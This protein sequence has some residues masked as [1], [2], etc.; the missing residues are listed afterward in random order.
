MIHKL[1]RCIAAA[2]IFLCAPLARA[3]APED[4]LAV[5]RLL[6]YVAVDYREAVAGGAVIN[7]GEYAEMREFAATIHARL[8]DLPAREGKDRLLAQAAGLA[9]AIEAKQ[10]PAR[11]AEQAAAMAQA[12]LAAYPAP[13]SPTAP[14]DVRAAGAL[15]AEHCATCHGASGR[16]DGPV[17]AGM[18][19]PPINFHDRARHAS[20]SVFALYG[21]IANGVEGTAMPAFPQLTDAQ[22]WALAFHVGQMPYAAADRERG[23]SVWRGHP[24]ARDAVPSLAALVATTPA[25]LAAALGADDASA[26]TAFLRATPSAVVPAAS[27]SLTHAIA[28]IHRSVEAFSAGDAGRAADLALA[29]YLDGFEPVEPALAAKDSALMRS[30]EG[31]MLEFRAA[32]QRGDAA[33]IA[34]AAR[35]AEALL[36]RAS[37]ALESGPSAAGAFASSFVILF[38]EG[39][40]AVLVLVAIIAGLR[41]MGRLDAMP[42]VHA[43][44]GA[45][46]LLGVVTWIAANWLIDIS[47][48]EREATEG[49]TGL[50]AV[51]ILVF[52]GLWLHSQALSGRWQTYLNEAIRTRLSRNRLWGLSLLAFVAVYREAFEVVLFY[53]ALWQQGSHTAV[54]AGIGAAIVVLLGVSWSLFRA[55][56]KLPLRHFFLASS[57]FIALLAIVMAGHA[58]S[59]LQEAGWLGVTR[60]PLP[61]VEWLGIHPTAQT[62]ALQGFVALLL[63]TGLYVSRL[64]AAARS[65]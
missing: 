42:Y 65:G 9:A 29:A 52:V 15:Y 8:R 24:A 27:Q 30:V 44:W 47:G 60:W 1:P 59:A 31:A 55:S 14:P 18:E 26:L 51:A 20:R 25:Q 37:A 40:E 38:R 7:A 49:V 33:A 58:A 22:R 56:V 11:V 41:R 3:G 48:A 43:G 62:L 53:G 61:A 54:L 63:A 5:W 39:L 46:V 45:A 2:L 32:L 64:R 6:D 28:L 10:E 35:D 19:P 16:G 23:E 21:I 34:G 50:I 36:E 12:L 17:A 57:V 4:A 13:V